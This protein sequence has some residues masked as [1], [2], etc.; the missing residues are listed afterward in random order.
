MSVVSE[1]DLTK[2]QDLVKKLINDRIYRCAEISPFI[3][4]HG[5]LDLYLPGTS[6]M[7]K[8]PLLAG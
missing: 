8:I 2:P 7:A 5:D 4:A 6:S 3:G 1:A